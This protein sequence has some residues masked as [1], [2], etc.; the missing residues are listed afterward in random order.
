MVGDFPLKFVI[1]T[2][3]HVDVR[4]TITYWPSGERCGQYQCSGVL[5]YL[6]K[7]ILH[8]VLSMVHRNRPLLRQPLLDVR[9]PTPLSLPLRWPHFFHHTRSVAKS[10]QCNL[11]LDLPT[12]VPTDGSFIWLTWFFRR[13]QFSCPLHLVRQLDYYRASHQRL[14]CI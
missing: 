8:M 9:W 13:A 3:E 12:F 2:A 7:D 11:S 14:I 4:D 1:G 10:R 5:T 6:Y